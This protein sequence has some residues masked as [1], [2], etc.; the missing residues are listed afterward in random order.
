MFEKYLAENKG[1]VITDNEDL[2]AALHEVY[3]NIEIVVA[4]SEA[5]GIV[6]AARVMAEAEAMQAQ[7]SD[8]ECENEDDVCPYCGEYCC[9]CDEDEDEDECEE[10]EYDECRSHSSYEECAECNEWKC[11]YCGR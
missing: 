8:D 4:E 3:D 9:E 7:S 11:P 10:D 1:I 2:A 5:E 6:L